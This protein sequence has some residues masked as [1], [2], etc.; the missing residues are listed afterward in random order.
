MLNH[1]ISIL[2]AFFTLHGLLL[3]RVT[4]EEKEFDCFSPQFDDHS[5]TGRMYSYSDHISSERSNLGVVED[6]SDCDTSC[7]D[8][9]SVPDNSHPRY[10]EDIRNINLE[11]N[12]QP[13]DDQ[14]DGICKQ[15]S[16][17]DALCV[18][19]KQLLVRPSVL[20]CGHGEFLRS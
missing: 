6:T 8:D 13:D 17:D 1:F 7:H 11:E 20:N 10:S 3:L 4:E 12:I 2:V 15:V 5:A 9:T 16:I 18:A 19:C 14:V